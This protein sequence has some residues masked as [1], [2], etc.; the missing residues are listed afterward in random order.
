MLMTFSVLGLI[1]GLLCAAGDILFDFKVGLI[2]SSVI[3][4]FTWVVVG[5]YRIYGSCLTGIF[6][7]SNTQ[8]GY[9]S[10]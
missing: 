8:I 2:D 1:G 3:C 4:Y 10:K 5:K 7:S 9:V 6:P